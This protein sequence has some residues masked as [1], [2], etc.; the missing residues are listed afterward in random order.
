MKGHI[1]L[2]NVSFRYGT[3]RVIQNLDFTIEPGEMIG[4]VGHSGSGKARSST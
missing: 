1:E 2:R 3:R 4:L